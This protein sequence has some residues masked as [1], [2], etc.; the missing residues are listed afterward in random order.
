MSNHTWTT[1]VDYYHKLSANEKEYLNAFNSVFFKK[2]RDPE[3]I[4][5]LMKYKPD[6][7]VSALDALDN[8]EK[9]I[10][11]NIDR[12]VRAQTTDVMNNTLKKIEKSLDDNQERKARFYDEKV[13]FI[14]S[15]KASK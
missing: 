15:S 1:D 9:T 8:P 11:Q 3:H 6:F 4:A 2:S 13:K 10:Q 14:E 12:Q 5:I 7:D